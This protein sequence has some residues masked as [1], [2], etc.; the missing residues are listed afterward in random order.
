MRKK[1]QWFCTELQKW[2]KYNWTKSGPIEC[3]VSYGNNFNY[4]SGFKPHQLNN[5]INARDGKGCLTY[6]ISDMDR[7]AKPW[8]IDC[9][10]RSCS[11][12]AFFWARPRN[13][14]F[15][16]INPHTIQGEIDEN[17]KSLTEDRA[18]LIAD[19]IGELK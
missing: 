8:D 3:K 6:K 7:L 9:Y 2:L 15:Y 13:R 14:I 1:E 18:K 10:F 4:N 5:L 16:L 11:M 19:V 12:V 17:K